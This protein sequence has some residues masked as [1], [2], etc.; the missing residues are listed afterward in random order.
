MTPR[1][2]VRG[3]SLLEVLIAVVV[4][5]I[6]LLGMVALHMRAYA[7]ES[8]SYQRAHAA[9]LLEDITNRMRANGANAAD[10][11]AEDIG[12]GPQEDCDG[13][14][15]GAEHDLCEWANLLRGAAE[16]NSGSNVGAMTAGRACIR[17]TAPDQY[18]ITLA[19]QGTVPTAAPSI[20]CGAGE[21]GDERVRRALVTVVRI[22]DLGI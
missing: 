15:A 22:A 21:F 16:T 1:R 10:Y 5:V 19:W 18:A 11:V 20:D 6:G 14:A 17:S 12:V 4:T 3:V 7:A 8:E 2:A 9:I 13:L